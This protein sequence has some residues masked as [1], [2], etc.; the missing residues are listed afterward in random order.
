MPFCPNCRY[1]YEPGVS[2]CADCGVPLVESLP[3]EPKPSD[4][5]LVELNT[6]PGTMYAEMVKE[7]LEK[8]GIGCVIKPSA[9]SGGLLVNAVNAAG[10][11]CRIF[12]PASKRK[13]AERI[14]TEMMDHI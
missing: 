9:L 2:E 6:L 3:E 7:V 11:E 5:E 10:S 8:E 12:V 14:L 4:E 13:R 1:E